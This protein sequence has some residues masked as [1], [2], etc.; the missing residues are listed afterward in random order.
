MSASPNGA[1]ELLARRRELRAK[2]G[3]MARM[4]MLGLFRGDS[5][6][7]SARRPHDGLA[8][9]CFS[10]LPASPQR[11]QHR[12]CA[13]DDCGFGKDRLPIAPAFQKIP[14]RLLQGESA[15]TGTSCELT[16]QS[17]PDITPTTKTL[18]KEGRTRRALRSKDSK[19]NLSRACRFFVW[20]NSP[21][22]SKGGMPDQSHEARLSSGKNI[23]SRQDFLSSRFAVS[24][25][26]NPKFPGGDGAR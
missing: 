1:D 6:P 10:A 24:L 5:T 18:E 26:S 17:R 9:S 16:G 20:G 4:E 2:G 14:G 12:T 8:P 22:H 25:A 15:R 13:A 7:R 11:V 23:F 21:S 3:V 19:R